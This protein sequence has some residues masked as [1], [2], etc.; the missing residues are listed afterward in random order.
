MGQLSKWF[1]LRSSPQIR[2]FIVLLP[3]ICFVRAPEL[4]LHG[5]NRPALH[6]LQVYIPQIYIFRSSS[7]VI[8]IKIKKESS[9]NIFSRDKYFLMFG[10]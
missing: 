9:N 8:L 5:E 7:S 4:R 1:S 10:L 3:G 6:H 2:K